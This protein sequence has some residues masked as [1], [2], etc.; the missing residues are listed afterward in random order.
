MIT[1]NNVN[2]YDIMWGSTITIKYAV[3]FSEW[4]ADWDKNSSLASHFHANVPHNIVHKLCSSTCILDTNHQPRPEI[5]AANS[6]IAQMHGRLV[7]LP[8]GRLSIELREIN[9]N[10]IK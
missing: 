2:K 1:T 4:G 6:D 3:K 8:Q 5:R 7:S 10:D 9:Y